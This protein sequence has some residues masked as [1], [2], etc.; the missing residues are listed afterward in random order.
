MWGSSGEVKEKLTDAPIL[1]L[2]NFAKSF[3]I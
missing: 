2:P 3:A 1:A